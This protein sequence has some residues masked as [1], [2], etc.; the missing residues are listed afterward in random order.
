MGLPSARALS[1]PEVASARAAAALGGR[2]RA[3]RLAVTCARLT[4]IVDHSVLAVVSVRTRA[5]RTSCVHA[6]ACAG[7]DCRQLPHR[8]VSVAGVARA[9]TTP[10]ASGLNGGLSACLPEIP[11]I[12]S[13]AAAAPYRHSHLVI[14]AN[15]SVRGEKVTSLARWPPNPSRCW[16]LPLEDY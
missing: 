16:A 6:G 5:A 11:S 9:R 15:G 13:T 7:D 14:G 12:N 10:P 1:K 4:G 2:L 3:A 8:C